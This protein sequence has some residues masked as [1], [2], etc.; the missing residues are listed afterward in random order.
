MPGAVAALLLSG[1]PRGLP[2]W[3]DRRFVGV[4]AAVLA[5]GAVVAPAFVFKLRLE[6]QRMMEMFPWYAQY[7][8]TVAA[9]IPFLL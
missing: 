6:E 4:H 1:I 9:L 2:A 8:R 3:C 5:G 7:R